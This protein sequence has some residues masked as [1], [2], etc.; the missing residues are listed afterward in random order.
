MKKL[1]AFLAIVLLAGSAHAQKVWNPGF[2]SKPTPGAQTLSISAQVNYGY[3]YGLTNDPFNGGSVSARLAEAW[4]APF[5]GTISNAY[6]VSD[7]PAT[8][9]DTDK[10]TLYKSTNSGAT[11][12]ATTLLPAVDS[13]K[14]TG[15]DS[16]HV[17]S[18]NQY[19]LLCWKNTGNKDFGDAIIIVEVKGN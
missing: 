2:S 5:A 3:Y 15:Y 6:I 7:N 10:F 12:V 18:F 8:L 14:H 4:M 9:A 11:W 1:F 13:G 19:D 16:T 17:V